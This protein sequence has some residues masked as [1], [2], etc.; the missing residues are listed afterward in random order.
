MNTDHHFWIGSTHLVCQDY[1]LS[2]MAA[3]LMPFAI[4]CDGCSS[5]PDSDI[6][7]RLIARAAYRHIE[8][9]HQDEFANLVINEARVQADALCLPYWSLDSTL[10]VAVVKGPEVIAKCIGD[11]VIAAIYDDRWVAYETT[12]RAGAPDYLSYD[13]D[14]DR[15]RVY[16]DEFGNRHTTTVIKPDAPD[17]MYDHQGRHLRLSL[18]ADP[19]YSPK[20]VVLMSDGVLSFYKLIQS[21][22][23]KSTKS[24]PSREVY[25]SLLKFKGFQ[26]RFIERRA[27]RFRLDT[28]EQG[29]L[30]ADDVGLAGIHIAP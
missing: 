14:A 28:L 11:G 26:G 27:K 17:A 21:D 15:R 1:A 20:A 8:V 4:V 29:W 23:S 10:L 16:L 13:L 9:A 24:I 5:A 25:D 12:Y 3:N 6:G 19:P 30:H 7:A 22:T 18:L 2:G